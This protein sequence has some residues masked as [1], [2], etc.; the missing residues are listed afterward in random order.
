MR[1]Q[2]RG[3]V[4]LRLKPLSIGRA[5]GPIEA[6]VYAFFAYAFTPVQSMRT[7]GSLPT[8]QAS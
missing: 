5:D 4:L 3:D 8:V 7:H 6:S 1:P 2:Y